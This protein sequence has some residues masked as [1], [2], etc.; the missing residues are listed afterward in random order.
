MPFGRWDFDKNLITWNNQ[1]RNH[2]NDNY[3]PSP[4][5]HVKEKTIPSN[6]LTATHKKKKCINAFKQYVAMEKSTNHTIT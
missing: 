4:G 3:N 6:L 1:Y 2:K 5:S